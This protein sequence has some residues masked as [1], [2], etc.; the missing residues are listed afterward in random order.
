VLELNDAFDHKVEALRL[1]AVSPSETVS[2]E[3]IEFFLLWAS[4]SLARSFFYDV[5]AEEK[6]IVKMFAIVDST[7][8]LLLW[9][10]R[11][12]LDSLKWQCPALARSEARESWKIKG[13]TRAARERP[14]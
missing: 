13:E 9:I 12:H 10:D 6:S 2:L 8:G 5:F 3:V 1:A 14:W 4:L 7:S 11:A